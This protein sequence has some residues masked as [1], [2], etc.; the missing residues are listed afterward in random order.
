MHPEVAPPRKFASDLCP[1]LRGGGGP[2]TRAR[3]EWVGLRGASRAG[4]KGW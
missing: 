1:R 4:G 2:M 3:G